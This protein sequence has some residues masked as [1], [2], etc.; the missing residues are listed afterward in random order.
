MDIILLFLI[1][2]VFLLAANIAERDPRWKGIHLVVLVFL[3]L[4]SGVFGI[5][6]VW[7][8]VDPL[9][10]EFVSPPPSAVGWVC[11]GL[12]VFG[13]VLLLVPVR[14][15]L[16]TV[17]PLY[18]SAPVHLTALELSW[19]LLGW[20]VIN[21]VWLGGVEGLQS[22]AE[23]VPISLYVIQSVGMIAVTLIG[24]GLF[25]RRSWTQVWD[26]LG[27]DSFR[28]VH[29]LIVGLAILALGVLNMAVSGLW[30]L[31]DPDQLESISEISDALMGNFDSLGAIVL[32]SVLSGLSE[33]LLFR[34][35]LQP[36]LGI[37]LTALV[38]ASTHIQYALSPATV[39]VFVIGI[40]LGY[41]RR[42]FGTVSAI[43][44]HSGYNFSLLLFGYI[45]E[46]LL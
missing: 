41:M 37:L 31:I 33:E 45:A 24:V 26:R 17:L 28:W 1:P 32:L 13:F 23:D 29:L 46:R 10:G 27:L 43:L 44:T 5:I 36:R 20:G 16:S 35:A 12:S 42:H 3:N 6:T 2:F 11:L 15:W 30:Y 39:T 19:Y 25:V 22:A 34:G 21:L 18:P 8:S 9:L 14:R 4:A 38:F 7:S 40:A